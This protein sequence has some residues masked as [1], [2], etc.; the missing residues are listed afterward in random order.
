MHP[1]MSQTRVPS[2]FPSGRVKIA[3]IGEGPGK[4]EDTYGEPW[5]GAA[6]QELTEMCKDAGLERGQLMLGNLISYRPPG[7]KFES[8]CVSRKDLTPSQARG[9]TQVYKGK[10]IH[11]ELQFDIGRIINEL[12]AIKPNLI[13]AFGAAPMGVLTG[14]F[15]ITKSRGA[16]TESTMVPGVKVLGT[17]HPAAVLRNWSHRVVVLADLIKAK[18]EGEFPQII[19]P[20]REVWIEPTLADLP[21]Y[22]NKYLSKSKLI[23]IDIE[24]AHGQITCISFAPDRAHSLV[25]PFVNK[26][27]PTYSYWP[28]VASEV[29]AWKFVRDVCACSTPKLL[30]NGVYDFQWL[31]QMDIPIKYYYEDTLLLHH[32]LYPELPKSLGFLGSVY[33]NEAAWKLYAPRYYRSGKSEDEVA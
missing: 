7:N 32:S 24:T 18:R 26:S 16:I 6:G 20:K 22:W 19:R 9:A 10:F 30:Q 29:E 33:T 3:G 21:K 2:I 1:I 4:D 15:G 14:Q 28:D 27:S 11:P 25:I 5:V 31:Y 23:S 17:F 13:I 12:I 8:V